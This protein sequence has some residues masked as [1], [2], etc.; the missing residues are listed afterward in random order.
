MQSKLELE[1]DCQITTTASR[2]ARGSA[3]RLAS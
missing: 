3:R 1:F 2:E